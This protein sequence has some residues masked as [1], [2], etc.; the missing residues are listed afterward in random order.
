[1][2]FVLRPTYRTC[3][4]QGFFKSGPGRLHAPGISKNASDTVGIPLKGCFRRRAINPTP[5]KRF[6]ACGDCPLRPEVYPVTRHT[7][8][9]P[10]VASQLVEMYPI[11]WIICVSKRPRSDSVILSI[12]YVNLILR[13][14]SLYVLS[15]VVQW[16]A[17]STS[18]PT[19]VS[20]SLIGCPFHMVL[21]HI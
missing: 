2:V 11:N 14:L 6:K 1:M 10:S 3:M 4:A 13:S 18:K 17:S 7:R 5:P 21:C 9:E 20:L 16:L 19:R 8:P 12:H 15:L